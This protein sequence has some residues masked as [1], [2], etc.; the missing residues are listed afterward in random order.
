MRT[1]LNLKDSTDAFR[2]RLLE[3]GI[4]SLLESDLDDSPE[5]SSSEAPTTGNS[6][7]SHD[8]YWSAVQS[9]ESSITSQ[10]SLEQPST[11]PLSMVTNFLT[12]SRSPSRLS[13][14]ATPQET[15]GSNI[16]WRPAKPPIVREPSPPPPRTAPQPINSSNEQRDTSEDR[17]RLKTGRF[18]WSPSSSPDSVGSPI[19]AVVNQFLQPDTSHASEDVFRDDYN[20]RPTQFGNRNG[21]EQIPP[22]PQY[23]APS[24]VITPAAVSTK[25][26]RN[27]VNAAPAP[28][29]APAPAPPARAVPEA[30]RRGRAGGDVFDSPYGESAA[31]TEYGFFGGGN[32]YNPATY[33]KQ[34][35]SSN[36]LPMFSGS[37]N[38]GWDAQANNEQAQFGYFDM[39]Q[40]EADEAEE[41][42]WM[43]EEALKYMSQ[44]P[45]PPK[46]V[47]PKVA[48][49]KEVAPEKK[50]KT[51]KSPFASL[52]KKSAPSEPVTSTTTSSASTVRTGFASKTL[53]AAASG[54]R[55]STIAV[56]DGTPFN[57]PP[58]TT[59][60]LPS[61]T[62]TSPVTAKPKKTKSKKGSISETP[63]EKE[64]VPMKDEELSMPPMKDD[65]SKVKRRGSG[66][67][68]TSRPT[69]PMAMFLGSKGTTTA[70]RKEATSKPT[71][72][73]PSSFKSSP[74]GWGAKPKSPPPVESDWNTDNFS[75]GAP[76]F[77]VSG[78]K[79]KADEA[80][81]MAIVRSPATSPN[82]GGNSDYDM[83]SEPV[84]TPPAKSGWKTK[85]YFPWDGKASASSP[86]EEE[87][88]LAQLMAQMSYPNNAEA[89]PKA[90][91]AFDFSEGASVFQFNSSSLDKEGDDFWSGKLGK[92]TK[93][94]AAKG[95]PAK[96]TEETSPVLPK[97]KTMKSKA[98]PVPE[99]APSEAK[100]TTAKG[101]NKKGAAK[102]VNKSTIAVESPQPTPTY[103][104]EEWSFSPPSVSA[105]KV[106]KVDPP[107]TK[108]KDT[109]SFG[110]AAPTARTFGAAVA[111]PQKASKAEPVKQKSSDTYGD[112]FGADNGADEQEEEE[113]ALNEEEQT[114]QYGD[115]FSQP[116]PKAASPPKA[117]VI[118]PP[119]A[120]K[121]VKGKKGAK[122]ETAPRVDPILEPVA[123]ETPEQAEPNV[124]ETAENTDD[125]WSTPATTKA[126]AKP[127]ATKSAWGAPSKVKPAPEPV[128]EAKAP[129]E[130]APKEDA[131]EQTDEWWSA[132]A[133]GKKSKNAKVAEPAK[134]SPP[135]ANKWSSMNFG[136][137]EQDTAGD[138]LA[139]DL[140]ATLDVD[141]PTKEAEETPKAEET[142]NAPEPEAAPTE[143]EKE[144]EKP[145]AKGAKTVAK[146][147]KGKR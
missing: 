4:D 74:F 44:A 145:A 132:P 106:A 65:A 113:A 1:H 13:S 93:A 35:K 42:P 52:S 8:S 114:G 133:K 14:R 55:K 41:A 23:P 51:S 17:S 116:K 138:E 27:T 92:A 2:E 63:K 32:T 140:E 18:P 89:T 60:N 84:S 58:K 12:R 124:E 37:N 40:Y 110:S 28:A 66:A 36:A 5:H 120:S 139:A 134:V 46:P 38:Y 39:P 146:K 102:T 80:T 71:M 25:N 59:I 19:L 70:P 68:G 77:G 127:K 10:S 128:E 9:M 34:N 142:T 126:A 130:V 62:T 16:P 20:S 125:W 83:V 48:E 24:K 141:E 54:N 82:E 136:S 6:N 88:D 98:D 97:S 45:V 115:W 143:K 144:A 30:A 107:A 121:P 67:S 81:S 85:S 69:S 109:W 31:P 61:P 135:A 117:A 90:P 119:P 75:Y 108:V 72:A 64:V 49:K 103:E 86:K 50:T 99:P 43:P 3:L 129:E 112:W 131:K 94:T 57:T 29:S 33:G 104:A 26:R 73:K 21:R 7:R 111:A 91:V 79:S 87:E 76:A 22:T 56:E 53:F 137:E 147:K 122:V 105:P 100:T 47:A 11:G 95:E 78:W 96:V 15:K 123:P 118:T 101:K